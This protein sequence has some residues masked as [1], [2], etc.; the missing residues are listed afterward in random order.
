MKKLIFAILSGLL[1]VSVY[2]VESKHTCKPK[3]GYV[4]DKETAIAIAV[5][6][7]SPI[8]GKEHIE[9]RKPYNAS[10]RDN[11]WYVSGSLPKDML[12]G[13]PEMEISKDD[14]RILRVTHGK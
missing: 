7:W 6:V 2:A 9:E 1:F 14:G 11:V 10:L 13:V 4:P 8:Y 12:G 3:D 5:A